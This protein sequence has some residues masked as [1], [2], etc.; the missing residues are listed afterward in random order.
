MD[1]FFYIYVKKIDF[2]KPVTLVDF[3]LKYSMDVTQY[4]KLNGEGFS[5]LQK[6]ILSEILESKNVFIAFDGLD[7]ASTEW[8]LEYKGGLNMHEKN[9]PL[10]Y[11]FGLM[12]GDLLPNAKKLFTSRQNHFLS[13]DANYRPSFVAE[14]LGLNTKSQESLCKQICPDHEDQVWKIIESNPNLSYSCYVPAKCVFI[15]FSVWKSLEEDSSKRFHSLT[16]I[17]AQG[18]KYYFAKGFIKGKVKDEKYMDRIAKLA[19]NGFTKKIS[20]FGKKDL[21]N[22]GIDIRTFTDILSAFTTEENWGMEILDCDRKSNFSHLI[23]QEYFAA[24]Y[25]VYFS[26]VDEFCEWIPQFKSDRWE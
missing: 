8:N 5:S 12:N 1:W 2:Q 13:I 14:V 9:N 19:W 25:L 11:L 18:F 10:L 15:T 23:W 3:L 16:Q 22:V 24:C 17:F 7:E 6:T 21:D 4:N 26:S 20:I